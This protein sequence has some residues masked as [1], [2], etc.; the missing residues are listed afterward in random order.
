[1]A[2][3]I[4]GAVRNIFFASISPAERMKALDENR[5]CVEEAA[6]LGAPLIVL[7]CGADPRQSL[8]QSRA[9][10]AD[11]IGALLP[12]AASA[13]VKLAVEPLHP[14][15]AADRSAINTLSQARSLC[16]SFNS[17][18]LG[19]AVDVY[20]TW[21]DD[22]L[23][24]EIAECGREGRLLALHICDW[25]APTVDLLNDRALMGEGCIPVR[26]IR[27]WM[28]KAGFDGFSEV[29]IFSNRHWARDPDQFLRDIVAAYLAHA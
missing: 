7:V 17:P 23:E 10:I 6:A 29:E 18:W 11:A 20:H 5:R 16:R 27:G 21:W 14:M 3:F 4:C 24:A 26:Q 28:E 15:Y 2:R 1:M 9:Q 13:G 12:Y 25:R 8:D 22:R 19:I